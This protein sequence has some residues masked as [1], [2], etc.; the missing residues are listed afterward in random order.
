MHLSLSRSLSLCLCI[1]DY[2]YIYT[3]TPE[4]GQP[5]ASRVCSVE[6]GSS[7]ASVFDSPGLGGNRF[8]L[9]KPEAPNIPKWDLLAL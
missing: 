6:S 3:S 4:Q 2:T 9:Y 7:G 1:L 5:E 8:G